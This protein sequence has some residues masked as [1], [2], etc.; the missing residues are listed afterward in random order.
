MPFDVT[1]YVHPELQ[2]LVAGLVQMASDFPLTLET[3][4]Q[5][6]ARESEVT[7]PAQ[8]TPSW[9]VRTI[10]GAVG[11]PDVRVVIVD[12]GVVGAAPRPAIVHMH[13]GGFVGGSPEMS[14][15]HTQE[16]ARV[17]RC[18]VVS[19]DYRRAPE[20]PFP[21][22]LEDNY[23]ALKWLYGSADELAVDR[24]RIA[25]VGESAGGG[26]AAML[27][28]AARDRGEVP[29]AFQALSYPMLDDRTGRTINKPLH[30]GAV[31]WNE[32]RNRFSWN[33]FLGEA[34]GSVNAPHG[35]VPARVADLRGLPAAWI[36]VGSIDLFVDEDIEYARRLIEAGVP[37][38]L[39]VV[40]GAFHLFDAFGNTGIARDFR[41]DMIASL[42]A[43]LK[44]ES[45]PSGHGADTCA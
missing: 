21:G 44:S 10:P 24:A 1:P 32:E 6:R 40:P 29:I 28:I 2:H 26:H 13:G 8:L 14:L 27:A 3:L 39:N 9:S 4:P 18:V 43:A 17:L 7:A 19:T 23:A 20:T 11:A 16:L 30:I 42:G 22:A 45:V 15:W 25:V 41:A 5:L 36:G 38:R 37:T 31:G 12:P 35:A 34:A 33:C